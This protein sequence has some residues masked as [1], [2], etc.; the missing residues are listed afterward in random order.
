MSDAMKSP[1]R[2]SAIGGYFELEL[3]KGSGELY[4][5]ALKFPS[6]RAALT[7]LLL[8]LKPNRI[9][10]P[11][12]NCGSLFEAPEAAEVE[13]K[14]YSLER[15]LYPAQLDGFHSSDYLL[16]VNYFGVCAGQ[17]ARLL[18]DLPR[19]RIII[20]H[21]QAFYAPAPRSLAT[22]Y[23]PRKFFGVP[24]GGYLVTDL[25]IQ[26]PAMRD[27]QSIHRMKSLLIRLAEGPEA[28][29]S[30]F[31]NAQLS[32]QGQPLRGMSALTE[33]ML[34]SIDYSSALVRRNDNFTLLDHALGTVN[35]FPISTRPPLGPLCYPIL[36]FAKGLREWLIDHRVFVGRYWPEL[37]GPKDSSRDIESILVDQCVPLPCDQRYGAIEMD[38]VI[39]LVRA[40]LESSVDPKTTG[41]GKRL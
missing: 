14:R 17:V 24:D 39:K 15:N 9:W 3:P 12:Y 25:D 21:S 8:H 28:G 35:Q 27:D 5:D 6:A 20:D 37:S 11:S 7:S 10:M 1:E 29:Y 26:P 23:S 13:V 16:Y 2:S 34:R 30:E 33:A 22:L 31:R 36:T 18:D 19:D 38:R 40:F 4:P 41:Q 32:L